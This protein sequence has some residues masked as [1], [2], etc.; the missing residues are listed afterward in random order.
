M[1]Q[2]TVPTPVRIR[3]GDAPEPVDVAAG[4]QLVDDAIADRLVAKGLATPKRGRPKRET[5]AVAADEIER[6]E[7][8]VATETK[9]KRKSRARS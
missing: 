8:G 6:P 4:D 5:T 3:L 7:S 1:K 2:I 9:R